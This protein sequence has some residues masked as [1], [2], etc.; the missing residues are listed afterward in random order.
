MSTLSLGLYQ[1]ISST[2]LRG[3]SPIPIHEATSTA[4]PVGTWA[5]LPMVSS[6]FV[7]RITTCRNHNI[8]NST[9]TGFAK[10]LSTQDS[11]RISFRCQIDV[12]EYLVYAFMYFPHQSMHFFAKAVWPRRNLCLRGYHCYWRCHPSSNQ[13][14]SCN[15]IMAAC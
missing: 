7:V 6:V 3:D 2:D 14:T 13:R 4:K 10:A 11:A 1:P 15:V 5:N 8:T 9:E 12:Q